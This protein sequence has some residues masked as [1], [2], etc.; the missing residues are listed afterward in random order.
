MANEK[1]LKPFKEGEDKRRNVTGVNGKSITKY[2]K[3]LGDKKKICFHIEATDENGFVSVY[4][5]DVVCKGVNSSINQAIAAQ[6]LSKAAKGELRAIQEL[7]DRTEGKPKQGIEL[8]DFFTNGV[9]EVGYKN[10]D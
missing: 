5:D 3:E 8:D 1:N 7:L 4:K 2:L 6:L 9:I 10:D